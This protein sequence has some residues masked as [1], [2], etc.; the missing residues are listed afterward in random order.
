MAYS[1]LGNN[2]TMDLF[3]SELWL[4]EMNVIVYIEGSWSG[5]S[6]NYCTWIDYIIS[7]ELL[8]YTPY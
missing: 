1:L 7:I 5:C 6:V 4:S 3:V 8:T 2:I